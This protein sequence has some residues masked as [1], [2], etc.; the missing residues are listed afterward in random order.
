MIAPHQ[1]TKSELL[2][3]SSAHLPPRRIH[4]HQEMITLGNADSNIDHQGIIGIE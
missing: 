1:V 4:L 2:T 3:H